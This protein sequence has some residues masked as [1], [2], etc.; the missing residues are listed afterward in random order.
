MAISY[1]TSNKSTGTGSTLTFSHTITGS[2]TILFVGV[3]SENNNQTNSSDLVTGVTYNGN[4]MTLIAKTGRTAYSNVY[5]FYIIAPAGT[6]NV[7][8]SRSAPVAGTI[9]LCGFSSSYTGAQQTGQPDSSNIGTDGNASLSVSTTTIANNSWIVAVAINF[10]NDGTAGTIL[11]SQ[12]LRQFTVN[13]G[14]AD[15]NGPKSPAGSYSMDFSWSGA[16]SGA[17]AMVVA[18][19]SPVPS[20]SSG[21]FF[22]TSI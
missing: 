9:T 11:S 18:S 7:V 4:A 15:T 1:D 6:A 19:F 8:I 20:P 10:V 12:T 21:F 2:D 14:L 16:S 5:L 3:S 13:K 17:S 22:L